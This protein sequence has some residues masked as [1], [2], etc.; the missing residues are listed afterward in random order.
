MPAA[1]Q[2]F[3]LPRVCISATGQTPAELLRCARR[4]LPHSRFVELR[5]DWLPHPHEALPLIP[6]LLKNG[7]PV[8]QATCRRRDNGGR[9][10]GTVSEQ[11]GILRQAAQLGCRLVD[12]EIESAE[13]AGRDALD[14][15]RQHASLILS[16]HDFYR[17]PRLAPLARR[18]AR[19]PAEFY[20][21]VPTA[22]RQS[23]NC[24]V[25]DLLEKADKDKKWI[26]FCMGETGIPS[27]VLALARGSAFIYAALAGIEQDAAAPGQLDIHT[28][29]DLY[30]VENL[31]PHAALY[32]L[33]GNP[34]RHSVGAAVH[35][36]VFGA[37]GL[38]A[39]YLPLLA[40]QL[41]DFRKAALRYPLAGFS[42]TIPHKQKILRFVDRADRMVQLAGAANTVRIRKGRWEAT[43]TDIAGLIAPLR[44]AFRL[45]ENDALPGVF[46][47][48][49]VGTGG[50]ARAALAA[51]RLLHCRAIFITGRNPAKVRALAKEM[52]SQP[53]AMDRLAEETFDLLI[54][55][56][57]VGMWPHTGECLL[58]SEQLNAR[59]VFDLVYNP[60]ETLLLKRARARGCRTISGLEMFVAQAARQ[61]EYWTDLQPPLRLMRQVAERELA[62]LQ[63]TSGS[64]PPD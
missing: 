35:N 34:V 29:R 63:Q 53:F 18:L 48:V 54:H 60:V 30:R 31:S 19:F 56:T 52:G 15:L 16:F 33:L 36:A 42:V 13:Q 9:F 11:W 51:M 49:V 55:A 22:A 47:A 14:D 40:S 57:S 28:L 64:H 38:D 17:T 20:K 2:R 39:V 6:R 41:A 26:A 1:I 27:R 3:A 37:L 46:R 43:N 45:Q 4:A 23:D 59:V 62:R 25:L 32:G 24:A 8:L 7:N 44:K 61:F 5:L 10:A 58:E 50:A 21:L 12:L